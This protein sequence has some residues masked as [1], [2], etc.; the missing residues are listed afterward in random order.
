[1]IGRRFFG[2][3]LA[4]VAAVGVGRVAGVA[5]D[6]QPTPALGATITL[7]TLP[8]LAKEAGLEPREGTAPG[9][10]RIAR[11]SGGGSLY[12]YVS[13]STNGQ[14][15]WISVPLATLPPDQKSEWRKHLLAMLGANAEDDGVHFGLVKD[16][17]QLQRAVDNRAISPA[18]FGREVDNFFRVM[19][20]TNRVW[21]V[22]KWGDASGDTAGM[23]GS[24]GAAKPPEPPAPPAPPAMSEGR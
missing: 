12:A 1:M 23:G 8:V 7:E 20:H 13:L 6:G 14:Y 10:L 21:N 2:C 15:V 11:G 18:A 9:Q 4:A 5:A 24:A 16:E 19:I 22:T 17:I 3:V